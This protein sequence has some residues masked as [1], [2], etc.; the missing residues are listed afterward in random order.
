MNTRRLGRTNLIVSELALGTV[1]LGLTYG[2]PRPGE[3]GP[4]DEADAA[5]LLNRA[6]DAGIT[7]IDTARAYGT[8]EAVI[9]RAL[10]HRRGEIVLASKFTL[11]G[12]GGQLLSGDALRGHFWA[13]LDTSL[14][15]LRTDWLDLYQV[16]AGSD[17]AILAD[18]VLAELLAQA[19]AAGKI[20]FAGLSAYGR[21]LPLAGLATNTFDTLQVAYNVLD[22]RMEERVFPLARQQDV[23]IVVRSA[24]LKGALTDRADSLPPHLDA[25]RVAA[26]AFRALAADLPGRPTAV[27]A[28]LRF[29][30]AHPAIS[31]TLIGV[32]DMAELEEAVAV[33]SAPAIPLDALAALR[34]LSVPDERLLDPGTWGIP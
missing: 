19:R 29:C 6:V 5:R 2:I 25:L 13:S 8:A 10:R 16:H 17:P 12:P 14:R 23:G 22:R 32:R 31:A 27:Q 3:T 9:G 20:R 26:H 28:A 34:A 4:P 11:L 30:L 21:E 33:A 18:G 1:E 15:A 24:L 7:L